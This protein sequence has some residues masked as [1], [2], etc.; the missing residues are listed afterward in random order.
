MSRISGPTNVALQVTS[1]ACVVQQIS[2]QRSISKQF[3]YESELSGE[4]HLERSIGVFFQVQITNNV[5]WIIRHTCDEN[6]W[7]S[8][9]ALWRIG[10]SLVVR[11]KLNRAW[12]PTTKSKIDL[13]NNSAV[14]FRIIS[15][16]SLTLHSFAKHASYRFEV[17]RIHLQLH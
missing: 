3:P 5:P 13:T 1:S 7:E 9:Q 14:S 11:M 17:Q 16:F 12:M 6:P 8:P 10:I 15:D 2:W 4:T